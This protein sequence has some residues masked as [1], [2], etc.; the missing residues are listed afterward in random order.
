MK[1]LSVALIFGGRSVEHEVSIR[2]ARSI[3]E[4]LTGRYTVI[5]VYVTKEGRWFRCSDGFPGSLEDEELD[6]I[7]PVLGSGGHFVSLGNPAAAFSVD[8]AFP[9]IHGTCGEDGS[10]QGLLELMRLP[11]KKRG[12][13][14]FL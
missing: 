13:V 11:G 10:L 3:F 1:K 5:P 4:N 2:S 14:H 8:V 6:E 7:V 9:I 12:Q